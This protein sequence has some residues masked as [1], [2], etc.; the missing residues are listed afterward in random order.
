[1]DS[2][3][4]ETKISL[5]LTPPTYINKQDYVGGTNNKKRDDQKRASEDY[6]SD[7]DDCARNIDEEHKLKKMKITLTLHI[8]KMV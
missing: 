2:S 5:K 1:M 3:I 4:D 6:P 7:T 8:K